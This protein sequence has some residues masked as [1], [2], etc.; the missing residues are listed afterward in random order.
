MLKTL[1]LSVIKDDIKQNKIELFIIM[2]INISFCCLNLFIIYL[3]KNSLEICKIDF[4]IFKPLSFEII[5]IIILF[6]LDGLIFYLIFDLYIYNKTGTISNDYLL[7]KYLF[8]GTSKL[9]YAYIALGINFVSLFLLLFIKLNLNFSYQMIIS[10]II[11]L[12]IFIV[13][14]QLYYGRYNLENYKN[15]R[16]CLDDL[17]FK[18]SQCSDILNKYNMDRTLKEEDI[19]NMYDCLERMAFFYK[20]LKQLESILIQKKN[21]S[22]VYLEV[23]KD[24]EGQSMNYYIKKY[25]QKLINYIEEIDVYI[26]NNQYLQMIDRIN[27]YLS[28]LE[29]DINKE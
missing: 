11:S 28:S 16:Y 8:R 3:L 17:F 22:N 6:F 21:N 10:Y 24:F 14:E 23:S 29:K 4:N 9:F 5:S 13:L 18:I 15:I 12:F 1:F 2:L 20:E 7:N 25:Q 27:Y 26:N 19:I